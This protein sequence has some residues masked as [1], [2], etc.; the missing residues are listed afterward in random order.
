MKSNKT[1]FWVLLMVLLSCDIA[2]PQG[3]LHSRLSRK[4]AESL[5]KDSLGQNYEV[6]G[7]FD[8]DRVLSKPHV[9][10]SVAYICDDPNHQLKHTVIVDYSKCDSMPSYMRFGSGVAI[11]D[12]GGVALIR[13]GKLLWV[14]KR[15]IL[16][17]DDLRCNVSGF[18][19]LNDDG[20]MDI[21]ISVFTGSRQEEETLWLIST[22][23]QGGRVL[24]DVDEDGESVIAGESGS[25][26]FVNSRARKTIEI[27]CGNVVYKWNGSVFTESI[28]RSKRDVH[29]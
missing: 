26:K 15:F 5:L 19:D 22:E 18:A 11:N 25:F 10:P 6:G 29:R 23:G 12:T 9:D 27:H 20:V 7:I 1:V 28:D 4:A 13:D 21:I 8:V 17:Y 16:D 14:S 2:F 24:N 3:I